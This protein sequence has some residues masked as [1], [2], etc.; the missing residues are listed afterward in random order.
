[1]SNDLVAL[2]MKFDKWQDAVEAA[3]ST[4][5]L[6]VTG[7]V[8]GGQLIQYAD[9]SGAQ[10]NILAVEPFAT[11]AGFAS[12]AMSFAHITM[13]NDVLALCDIV[14]YNGQAVTSLTCNLAQGPLLVD[15]PEQRWQQIAITALAAAEGLE[16][17][18]TVE[19]Y[20][21][22]TGQQPGF[23]D[24]DGI[25]V[26]AAGDGSSRPDAGASFSARVLESDYRTNAL[27]GQRFIHATVDGSFAYDVCLPDTLDLAELPK[28]NSVISGR[29]VM[30]GSL[31]APQG[32]GSSGGDCG[33]GSCGCGGH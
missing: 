19:D 9:S 31:L 5:K 8:R 1:M 27:T 30:V 20:V 28:K 18:P 25:S 33:S 17:Y 22:A 12:V 7:E 10:I 21:A 13:L 2:G 6:S 23:L 14:D 15:E 26:V 3:I 4:N 24:S 32:C 16:Y 11:Y 29:A